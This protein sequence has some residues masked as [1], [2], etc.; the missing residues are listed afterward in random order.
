MRD[1]DI[2]FS[3][4]I[5]ALEEKT[6][7]STPIFDG[8][9]LHVRFDEIT[10]PDGKVATREY[11]HHNG[12]V[13][14]IP[15]TDE[16]EV[17]CVRQYRYPFHEDLLEIPA[18]KLDS[19]DEDPDDAVRRELREE[20]GAMAKSFTY[21]GKY[22]PSP[23]ILDECI[24]MYMAEGLCFGET[25]FDDDEFIETLRVP[26]DK[27]VELTLD[28]RIRDGKTQICALRAHMMLSRR[29]KQE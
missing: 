24:H 10:L 26:L 28:G 15:I 29:Q 1:L 9:V 3:L 17:I 25:E 23:A 2:N 20:T 11:C 12:A 13:C 19:P 8:K 18:G 14:V 6:L 4:P 21:L 27:L 16:G 7:S 22:Y 5:E